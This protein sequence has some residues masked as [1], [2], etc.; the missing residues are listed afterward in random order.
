MGL[1]KPQTFRLQTYEGKRAGKARRAVSSALAVVTGDETRIRL[2][3]ALRM[4][5]NSV[6][7]DHLDADELDG[8]YL[9]TIRTELSAAREA[10][11][12]VIVCLHCGGQFNREPGELSRYFARFFAENGA[13]AVVCHHAHVV[14]RTE[15]IGSVPVAY[16]IGNYSISPSS[17]YLLPDN[18]PEYSVALHLSLGENEIG[19]SFSVLKTV[20]DENGVPVVY[21]V[22][23]LAETLDAAERRSLAADVGKIVERMTGRAGAETAGREY[24]LR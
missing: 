17:V 12:T 10:A 4:S 8:Q 5:Y 14:Q 20:E 7:V 9:E 18:L 19:A 6:R 13:D 24:A 3:R 21:P 2:K 16:C 11:D 22:E 1:L 15:W 23:E